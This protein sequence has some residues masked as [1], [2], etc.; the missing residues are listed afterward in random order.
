MLLRG[1]AVFAYGAAVLAQTGAEE[2]AGPSVLSRGLSSSVTSR[3]ASIEFRPR[4]GANGIC[5]NGLTAVSIDA[6]G[7]VPDVIA[8]GV[9]ASAGL[10]GYHIW[11]RTQLGLDYSG[12]YRHYPNR[13]FYNGTD[14]LFS[15][16]LSHRLSKRLTLGLR[17]S[18]GTYSRNYLGLGAAGFFEPSNL[19]TPGANLFDSPVYYAS[20]AADVVYVLNARWSVDAGGIAYAARYR[21]TA[22]YGADSYGAHGDI[23]YRY[24]KYGSIG[25]AYQFIHSEFTK[26]FGSFDY[27]SVGLVYSLRIGRSWELGLM[28]GAG[29]VESL[30]LERVAVDPVIAAIT[31]QTSGVLA[32]YHLN[33]LPD[34]AVGITRAF[35][36]GALA[37]RYTRTISAGNGAYLASEADNASGSYS[38]N[39]MRH[40]GF[41][42]FGGYSKLKSI[43]QAIGAYEGYIA[44]AGLTRTLGAGLQLVVGIDER[45]Y[46][47][48]YANF[49][50][51]AMRATLGVMWTPGDIPLNL[52]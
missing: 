43:Q 49:H 42:V 6:R 46:S 18:A 50:R 5:D 33:Y 28:A 31:G 40:W 30:T 4:L 9:E 1:L 21:S 14:Q 36:R 19:Q 13:T 11:K 39:G 35:R 26:S 52:W 34:L 41:H 47:T 23:V 27:H 22:L 20:T 38:Y 24:S 17:E 25:A 51:D 32:A 10:S 29:R 37:L 3:R 15:L 44:G 2:Y 16:G 48:G 7:R 12:N 45:H 8:C